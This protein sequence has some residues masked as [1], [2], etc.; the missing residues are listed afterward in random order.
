MRDL[1]SPR[2][3]QSARCPVRELAISELTYPRVVQLPRIAGSWLTNELREPLADKR[4][5][6]ESWKYEREI[7]GQITMN[8]NWQT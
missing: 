1:S 2:V 7:T 4:E 3:D 8:N 5:I 6:K